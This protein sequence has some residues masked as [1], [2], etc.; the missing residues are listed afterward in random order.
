MNK[1]FKI[2]FMFFGVVFCLTLSA[3]STNPATGEQQFTALMPAGQEAAIGA[4]EHKKVE[5]TFGGFIDGPIKEYV[6]SIGTKYSS[7]HRKR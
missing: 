2:P 7:I 3:C 5:Q 1:A 6:N 4:Q